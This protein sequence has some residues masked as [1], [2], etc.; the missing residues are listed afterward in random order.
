MET[1]N[2]N[3]TPELDAKENEEKKKKLEKIKQ[4]TTEYQFERLLN[5]LEMLD[6]LLKRVQVKTELAMF[7][8]GASGDFRMDDNSIISETISLKDR[9]E[10][11]EYINTNTNNI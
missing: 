6:S 11:L 9:L 3:K 1:K 8:T 2:K 10:A 5:V 7:L 4:A